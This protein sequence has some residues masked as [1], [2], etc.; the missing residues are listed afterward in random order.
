MLGKFNNKDLGHMLENVIF[1][2]LKRFG[3]KIYIGKNDTN[4]V[5]FVVEKKEDCIY[6]SVF[7]CME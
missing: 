1:L 5:D 6:T 4:K 2:E 3:Y 7:I